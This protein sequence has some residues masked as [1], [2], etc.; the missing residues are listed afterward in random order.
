MS[1][2][3]FVKPGEPSDYEKS[4]VI[5]R[6][7]LLRMWGYGVLTPIGYVYLAC[8]I[9][10]VDRTKQNFDVGAFCARWTAGEGMTPT[11]REKPLKPGQLLAALAKLEEKE[12]ADLD[13]SSVQLGLWGC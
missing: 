8:K 1:E 12:M 4:N 3:T 13:L 10:G 9:D 5:T 6:E 11:E 2:P 7:E